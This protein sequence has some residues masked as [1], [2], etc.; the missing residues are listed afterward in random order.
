MI[1]AKDRSD[2]YTSV[3]VAATIQGIEDDAV[4]PP[5]AVFDENGL[6]VLLRD[7][8][9]GFSGGPETVDHDI[10]GQYIEL[11]LFLSLN[12]RLPSHSDPI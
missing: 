11:L 12:V 10:V 6:L 2:V 1:D 3:D 8:D 4:L 5:V 9:R 7:E